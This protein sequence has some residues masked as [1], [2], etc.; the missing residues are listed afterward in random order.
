MCLCP[1]P[2]VEL[3]LLAHPS[4]PAEL[5]LEPSGLSPAIGLHSELLQSTHVFLSSHHSEHGFDFQCSP[6]RR[7]LASLC[8]LV[9]SPI[10]Q[11]VEQSC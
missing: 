3:R 4:P 7:P 2:D 11:E 8:E 5:S 9:Q 6:V 10:Y 1:H